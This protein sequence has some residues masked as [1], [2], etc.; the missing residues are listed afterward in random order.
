MPDS[1]VSACNML[2][3]VH[4]LWISRYAAGGNLFLDLEA[5][6]ELTA[7]PGA[8]AGPA[9]RPAAG[10]VP[11]RLGR[12]GPPQPGRHE[13]VHGTAAAPDSLRLARISSGPARRVPPRTTTTSLAAAPLDDDEIVVIGRRGGPDFLDSELARLGHLSPWRSRSPSAELTEPAAVRAR[14]SR[15]T[16]ISRSVFFWYSAYVANS[17]TARSHH[18]ARSSPSA[19]RARVRVRLGPVLQV[20]LGVRRRS[21]GTTSGASGRRPARRPRRTRRPSPPA[22]PGSS[23]ACRTC[24]PR[25]VITT[26]GHWG[27]RGGRWPRGRRRLRTPRPGRGPTARA[28]LV[29]SFKCHG[30]HTYVGRPARSSAG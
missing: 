18:S 20:D 7:A 13:I 6:E 11:R 21:C 15:N 3:G 8:R 30:S 10:D 5:V 22:S 26:I 1:I 12:P 14:S 9:D 24:A 19:S 25:D 28:G 2:D 23:A 27:C 29:L 16:G 17:A 4:V